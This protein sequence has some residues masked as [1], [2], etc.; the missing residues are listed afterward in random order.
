MHEWLITRG[1]VDY[2]PFE[3]QMQIY[4]PWNVVICHEP[5]CHLKL[6]HGEEG[7][8]MC[9]EDVIHF[10]SKDKIMRWLDSLS[11][12]ITIAKE[13]RAWLEPLRFA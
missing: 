7:K 1:D 13:R 4:V 12:A 2:V 6:Q 5:K 8:G 3:W 9:L 10:H 11:E